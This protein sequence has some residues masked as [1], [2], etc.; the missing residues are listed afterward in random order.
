MN[1]SRNAR[2]LGGRDVDY[3]LCLAIRTCAG[4]GKPRT[5]GNDDENTPEQLNGM[6]SATADHDLSH[7]PI[8]FLPY[9][10]TAINKLCSTGNTI[11]Y[12]S[13]GRPTNMLSR[14]CDRGASLPEV[15][16]FNDVDG[17]RGERRRKVPL[18]SGVVRTCPLR[19]S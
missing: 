17:P 16:C 2:P 1:S 5:G 10:Q 9:L 14:F 8:R 3:G 12:L 15:R 7:W 19:L 11:T 18:L 4:P 6:A 13:P